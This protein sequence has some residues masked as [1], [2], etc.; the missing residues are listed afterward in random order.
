MENLRKAFQQVCAAFEPL[1]DVDGESG[2]DD[3]GKNISDVCFMARGESDTEYEDNEVCAFEEAINILSAKN[4]KCEKMYRKQ[5]F[6][7]ESLKSEIARLKSLI[8]NDDDCKSC[9]VLMNEISKIRE[10][11]VAHD[12][13]NKSSLALTFALHTRTLDEL[14]LTK[15]LLQKYQIDFHASLMFNNLMMFWIAQHAH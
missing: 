8:P 1:S 4:M 5:E 7:I 2:D 9:E 14:F 15:K 11:N 10:V 3:K 12:L 6:I 13:K